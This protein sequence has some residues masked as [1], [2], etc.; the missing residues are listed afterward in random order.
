METIWCWTQTSKMSSC[1][2]SPGQWNSWCFLQ[3]TPGP[4]SGR[5]QGYICESSFHFHV[6]GSCTLNFIKIPFGIN[7]CFIY[8]KVQA[9]TLIYY[10]Y[11]GPWFK[12]MNFWKGVLLSIIF[13][14]FLHEASSVEGNSSV[15]LWGTLSWPKEGFIPKIM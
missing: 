5:I 1:L 3:A 7:Q 10:L 9:G 14:L 8:L 4:F 11:I 15:F 13:L 12:W 2:L 6:H